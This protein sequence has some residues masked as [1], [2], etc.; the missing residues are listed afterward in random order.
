MKPRVLFV[1][2][3]RFR[4]PL[5]GAQKRK[6]DALAEVVDHRVLAAAAPGSPLSDARFHLWPRVR[7][8]LVDGP[9]LLPRAAG[10]ARLA[11]CASSAR[12]WCSSRA[13]TRRR[14]FLIARRI[15]RSRA[16]R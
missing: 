14:K 16:R 15:A 6:W 12:T 11:R 4:L 1:S 10:A 9:V 3:E 5:D 13:S 2:R 8:S 7:P